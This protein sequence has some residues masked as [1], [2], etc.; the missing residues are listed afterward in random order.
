M[1]DVDSVRIN[2]QLDILDTCILVIRSLPHSVDVINDSNQSKVNYF[3]LERAIH[4]A[5][6]CI[7]DIGNV[8]IDGFVM[9]DPGS[10][11]DIVDILDDEGVLPHDM[12]EPIQRIV[13]YRKKLVH[14]YGEV[15]TDELDH[16]GQICRE[17]LP[18]L[19]LL[20]EGYLEKELSQ[21]KHNL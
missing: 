18:H 2:R 19:R 3:A 21:W 7:A 14:M 6:E 5:V 4:I 16:V 12:T 20:I 15:T 13:T 8:L 1:Y 10:Y 9:R 17:Y 11:S